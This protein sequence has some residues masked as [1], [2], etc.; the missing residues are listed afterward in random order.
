MAQTYNPAEDEL[1]K[2]LMSDAPTSGGGDT[3]VA[4]SPASSSGYDPANDALL[5]SLMNDSPSES[6][7]E[8]GISVKQLGKDIAKGIGKAAVVPFLAA[9]EAGKGI[10]GLTEA[11][12]KGKRAP[13]KEAAEKAIQESLYVPKTEF[14]LPLLGKTSLPTTKK[15]AVF[16]AVDSA[17]LPLALGGKEIVKAGYKAA[18]KE[19]L[20]AAAKTKVMQALADFGLGFGYGALSENA[21]EGATGGDIVKAGL[22]SGAVS[23][24]FPFAAGGSIAAITGAANK[25]GSVTGKGLDYTTDLLSKYANKIP[26]TPKKYYWEDVEKIAQTRGQ[27]LAETGARALSLVKNVPQITQDFVNQYGPAARLADKAKELGVSINEDFLNKIEGTKMAAYGRA[28]NQLEDFASIKNNYQDV[29]GLTKAW[30]HYAD[31]IDRLKNGEIPG[32]RNA[33]QVQNEIT[34]AFGDVA[35]ETLGRIKQAV[36]E[37][38]LFSQR[39]LDE[40]TGTYLS[41]EDVARIREAH[42]SYIPHRVRKYL[43]A[44]SGGAFNMSSVLNP[45]TNP[46]RKAKGSAEEILGMDEA[47]TG[48]IISHNMAVKA[49]ELVSD[50]ID[51]GSQFKDGSF[52]PVKTAGMVKASREAYKQARELINRNTEAIKERA[53]LTK[54]GKGL[55]SSTKRI[56]ELNDEI[57]ELADEAQTMASE[58]A[59]SPTEIQARLNKILTRERRIFEASAVQ[60][61]AKKALSY[62]DL[63]NQTIQ[64]RLQT[65]KE[66]RAMAKE[67][68]PNKIKQVDI[69]RGFALQ[70]RWI[71]GVKEEW[72]VPSDISNMIKGGDVTGQMLKLMDR[73]IDWESVKTAPADVFSQTMLKLFTVPARLTKELTVN[74]NPLF[75]FMSNPIRDFSTAY[76]NQGVSPLA[77][78][79]SII[80]G[81]KETSPSSL[82][83]TPQAPK[84]PV[85]PFEEWIKDQGETVYH[86]TTKKGLTEIKTGKEAGGGQGLDVVYVS[87]EKPTAEQY[88]VDRNMDDKGLLARRKAAQTEYEL[89]NSDASLNELEE[90]D[91][92]LRSMVDKQRTGEVIDATFSGR[93]V[94]P[95][96]RD[97]KAEILDI[98]KKADRSSLN[99]IEKRVVANIIGND[100]TQFLTA[101]VIDQSPNIRKVLSD[102]G[103]HGLE[104]PHDA[105]PYSRG[106][107]GTQIA[108]LDQSKIK[109]RSQL[110]AEWDKQVDEAGRYQ[111]LPQTMERLAREQGSFM[112]GIYREYTDPA[113][114]LFAKTQAKSNPLIKMVKN[115]LDIIPAAGNMADKAIR[116]GVFKDALQKGSSP[117]EAAALARNTTTN[118]DKGSPLLKL[119]NRVIPFLNPTIQGVTYQ[120][121]KAKDEPVQ[122]SRRAMHSAIFPALL[123]KEWN[124]QFESENNRPLHELEQFWSIIVAEVD[125]DDGRGNPI[126]VPVRITIP[127]AEHQKL[128]G[129]ITDFA[130][131]KGSEMYP[132]ETKEYIT[133]LIGQSSPF[134]EGTPVPA[135]QKEYV[136]WLANYRFFAQRPTDPEYVRLPNGKSV[137]SREVEEYRKYSNYTSEVAKFIGELFASEQEDGTREGGLSPA[138]VDNLI[139]KGVLT[140]ILKGIDLAVRGFVDTE[141]SA[142]QKAAELPI[143]RSILRKDAYGPSVRETEQ[144]LEE[145]RLKNEQIFQRY[146]Q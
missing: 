52:I 97:G 104:Y 40:K 80:Q 146:E 58:L 30:M 127:K 116:L 71:D 64:S 136:E 27:K 123:I 15:K 48:N 125:G 106:V 105:L 79:R 84:V 91:S 112:G 108:V 120:L 134:T 85:K 39:W 57:N 50:I 41:A 62:A 17:T 110:K 14:D 137:P 138:K 11:A 94:N 25:F 28:E 5:N 144:Q 111:E 75:A 2:S 92:Q 26:E 126:K 89:T 133:K 56:S 38:G 47:F 49:Q 83:R 141:G 45:S 8:E 12:Y 55:L 119:L 68:G 51:V 21:N 6:V 18:G 31:D 59:Y 130:I 99:P 100:S 113:K 33:E 129:G 117:T 3:T 102:N 74:Q 95:F 142:L 77:V 98:F 96:S 139:K 44:K 32:G 16:Q 132:Q 109:T 86:G 70:N 135:G 19:L 122:F 121:K 114:V 67:L 36:D 35:P 54:Q 90:I 93:S 1:L 124:S 101:K 107:D 20:E 4:S 145:K 65:I 88:I 9:R 143:I 46:V 63:V 131:S 13:N 37:I 29:W 78:F 73:A 10:A 115:P 87:K 140:D 81:I 22:T 69:P 82:A 118:F 34:R 42:P 7:P 60:A 61:N 72:L 24:V 23:S 103:I 76:Q 43:E 66:L 128:L 53:M